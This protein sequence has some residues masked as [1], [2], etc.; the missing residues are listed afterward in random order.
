M[1]AMLKFTCEQCGHRIATPSR[2]LSQ[3]VTCPECG[4]ATHP[5]ANQILS[6]RTAPP[7]KSVELAPA[8]TAAPASMSPTVPRALP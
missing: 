4:H 3:L 6:Q 8:S 7:G 2:R 5:L 1:A